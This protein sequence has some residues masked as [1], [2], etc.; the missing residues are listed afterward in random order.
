[1]MTMTNVFDYLL[2]IAYLTCTLLGESVFSL[3]GWKR[4]IQLFEKWHVPVEMVYSHC[5]N[6]ELNSVCVRV[7]SHYCSNENKYLPTSKMVQR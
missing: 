1:M 5:C 6:T 3:E 4:V 7:S 2:R